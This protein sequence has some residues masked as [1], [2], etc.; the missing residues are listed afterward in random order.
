VR[1]ASAS[2]PAQWRTARIEERGKVIT[3]SEGDTG[4]RGERRQRE[5]MRRDKNPPHTFG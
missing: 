2:N 5:Q 3:A 4:E 1:S